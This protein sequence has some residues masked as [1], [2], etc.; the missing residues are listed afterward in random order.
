MKYSSVLTESGY[1][2]VTPPAITAA[3]YNGD[4]TTAPSSGSSSSSSPERSRQTSVTAPATCREAEQRDGSRSTGSSPGRGTARSRGPSRARRS[5]RIC[6][7]RGSG[8]GGGG[9][10][11]RRP[12]RRAGRCRR[13]RARR[14]ATVGRSGAAPQGDP[15]E[16]RRR[17]GAGRRWRSTGSSVPERVSGPAVGP[18]GWPARPRPRRPAT[19]VAGRRGGVEAGDDPRPLGVDVRFVRAGGVR[20]GLAGELVR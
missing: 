16:V 15:G 12:R 17:T 14:A 6:E 13:C 19:G 1:T 5:P 10:S 9:C 3:R 11:P 4:Q 20:R 2:T 7:M 18:C 8:G